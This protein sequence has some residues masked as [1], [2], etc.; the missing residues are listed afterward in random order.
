MRNRPS[1]FPLPTIDHVRLLIAPVLVFIVAG[2]DRG[3]QTDFWQHLARGQMIAT[4]GAVVSTD[5]FTFTVPGKPVYDNNWVTQVCYHRL[6]SWGGIELV[7][8]VNA[9]ILAAAMLVFVRLC[10]RLSGST[11]WAAAAGVAA[12]FGLWQTILIRP[13]SVSVLL[14]VLLYASLA[15]A[16]GN[17]GWRHLLAAP[18]IM[19]LW[20][21]VHGGFAVGLLL[22]LAFTLAAAAAQVGWT[23]TLDQH[24]FGTADLPDARTNP[25]G[26]IPMLGCLVAS[27]AATLLNPYG[28][29]VY[30]YAGR[31]SRIGIERGIEEWLAPTLSQP[32]GICFAASLV[33]LAV[34]LVA[35]RRRPVALHVAVVALFLPPAL[36]AVRMVPWWFLATLPVMAQVAARWSR[37]DASAAARRPTPSRPSLGAAAVLA[38]LLLAAVASVPWLE[39]RSPMF[40]PHRSTGRAEAPLDQVSLA[41]AGQAAEQG[42]PL[43]VFTRLEWANYFTATAWPACRIF[44]EGH[45]ELYDDDLWREYVAISSGDAGSPE[46]LDAHRVDVLVLDPPYHARLTSRIRDDARWEQIPRTAAGVVVFA[47]R[48]A[49]AFAPA[50]LARAP[51]N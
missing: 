47:R 6:F 24:P 31:L 51:A 11:G 8:F 20:A 15:R 13:Q 7:Q 4:Q 41:L 49:Q 32:V 34:L 39:Q 33:L 5:A 40:G 21:N 42:R 50:R 28:W 45:V 10:R 37:A 29:G 2:L 3:Y 1:K 44:M 43:R 18:A 25:V 35:S 16:R 23:R 19:L 12:F 17:A 9:S 38:A 27:A 30:A 46:L 48:N 22:I 26:V 36:L 14:F